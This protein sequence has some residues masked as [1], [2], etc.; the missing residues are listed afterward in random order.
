MTVVVRS[1]SSVYRG[2]NI[3]HDS[4]SPMHWDNRTCTRAYTGFRQAIHRP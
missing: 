4:P 1:F 2:L 3:S